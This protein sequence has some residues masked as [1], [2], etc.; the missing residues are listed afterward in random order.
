M[1]KVCHEI[2]LENHFVYSTESGTIQYILYVR[3]NFT[4]LLSHCDPLIEHNVESPAEGTQTTLKWMLK[5]LILNPLTQIVLRITEL[6][7][8]HL[9]LQLN[10]FSST[11]KTWPACSQPGIS[12]MQLK[13]TENPILQCLMKSMLR[14]FLG[15]ETLQSPLSRLSVHTLSI[16][17]GQWPLTFKEGVFH[18]Q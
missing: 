15:A 14:L 18:L 3:N 11:D 10:Y 6:S 7:V 8:A 2:E 5:W 9:S 16:Y 1:P 4:L 13:Q 17:N 12:G